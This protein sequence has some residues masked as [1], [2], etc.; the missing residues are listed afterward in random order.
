[1]TISVTF[2]NDKTGK[3]DVYIGKPELDAYT[4]TITSD[5]ST[6]VSVPSVRIQ[7]PTSIFPIGSTA[8]FSVTSSGWKSP[9]AGGPYLTL[10]PDAPLSLSQGAPITILLSGIT[11]SVSAVTSG[12][13]T[14][15]AASEAP[16]AKVFLLHYPEGAKDLSQYMSAALLPVAKVYRTPSGQKAIQNILSLNLKNKTPGKPLV[17]EGWTKGTPT[18]LLSFVYGAEAGALTT[19]GPTTSDPH[20]AWSIDVSVDQ[21]FRDGKLVHAWTAKNP[22][23][24]GAGSTPEWTLQPTPENPQ[25][26]GDGTGANV[27]FKIADLSTA[28]P[29]APTQAYLQY[30]G[31]PGYDDGYITVDLWVAEP[32]PSIIFF[33]G[34]PSRVETLG[35]PVKLNWQTFSVDRVDLVYDAYTGITQGQPTFKKTV[36]ST[37]TGDIDTSGSY[38]VDVSTT[39]R[40]TLNA[41]RTVSDAQPAFTQSWTADVPDVALTFDAKYD[42][43]VAGSPVA[44]NWTTQNALYCEITNSLNEQPYVLD[45]KDFAKGSHTVY[46]RGAAKYTL[47]AKGQYGTAGQL[48][49]SI[50]LM[51]LPQGFYRQDAPVVKAT[52]AP[53]LMKQDKGAFW[54]ASGTDNN[55]LL[56]SPNG[57]DWTQVGVAAFPQRDHAGGAAHATAMFVMGGTDNGGTAMNDVWASDNGQDWHNMSHSAEWS[58]RA[59]FGCVSFGGKLWV[60]G[61]YDINYQPLNEIWSSDDGTHW[62]QEGIAQWS[63]RSDFALTVCNGALWLFGGHTAA[64]EAA[65]DLWTSSDGKTWQEVST[66]GFGSNASIF[67]RKNGILASPD[68]HTLLLFGGTDA[69]GNAL[70][71]IHA[72][73]DGHWRSPIGASGWDVVRPGVTVANGTVWMVGGVSARGL[74]LSSVWT[75]LP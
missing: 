53:V 55:A 45:P 33:D 21:V 71:D 47:I 16:S 5:S 65:G 56:S 22:D 42:A 11:S 62:T 25:V 73:A 64:D 26:L 1:M 23:P 74:P 38:S 37:T 54:L 58:P 12:Q 27:L 69:N 72:Y 18:V 36:L 30:S 61:G 46:P 68:G 63:P 2:L 52:G 41:Y 13:I 29:A 24:G 66:G 19:D 14:V 44:L 32:Q 67:G 9:Q 6:A 70:R 59:R 48:T 15:H 8:K 10:T 75:Y 35:Q 31:F 3:P 4:L 51:F 7:F 60:I 34:S 39:T 17:T 49:K 40:F 28:V 57:M 43:P 20:S 50:D